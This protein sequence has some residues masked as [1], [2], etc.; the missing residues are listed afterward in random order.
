MLEALPRKPKGLITA[1]PSNPAGTIL[2]KAAMTALVDY[3]ATK[4]IRIIADE[5][6]HGITYNGPAETI[7]A[8]FFSKAK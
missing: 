2:D 3:C 4:H 1:S 8:H 6:Y 7:L 5:I